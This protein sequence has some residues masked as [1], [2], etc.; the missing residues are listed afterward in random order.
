[1]GQIK[2]TC[3]N[4]F[5]GK[6]F[7]RKESE[8]NR[9]LKANRKIFCSLTCQRIDVNMIHGESLDCVKSDK[10]TI[11][12]MADILK[13]CKR[14]NNANDRMRYRR[15]GGNI[16]IKLI[17][18]IRLWNNQKGICVYSKVNLILSTEAS[19]IYKASLD[20]IDS[21]KGYEIGNIQFIS[22]AMNLMKNTMPHEDVLK[23]LD[24]IKST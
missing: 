5:C 16:S 15:N 18:L 1:M 7:D 3:A 21:L 22:S 4:I 9:N 6:E 14:R 12:H 24:I 13:K 11:S 17:D 23:L 8:F 19:P 20:R 10:Q 2:V